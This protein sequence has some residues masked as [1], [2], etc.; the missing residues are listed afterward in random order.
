MDTGFDPV[1]MFVGLLALVVTFREARRSNRHLFR[2]VEC[3][4]S[5]CDSIAENSRMP[6]EKLSVTLKNIG[7]PSTNTRL[8]LA[9][10]TNTHF[11]TLRLEMQRID[12][13]GRP[14][15]SGEF[16][17]GSFATFVLKSY[18]HK[19]QMVLKCLAS[20]RKP[21]R[22]N[23]ARLIVE[24]D[25]FEIAVIKIGGLRDWLT[26]LW[27]D[28]AFRVNRYSWRTIY[29][30]GI[31]MLDCPNPLPTFVSVERQLQCYVDWINGSH[32]KSGSRTA[33]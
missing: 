29:L 28:V 10:R 22:L 6:F 4:A 3:T 7:L 26:G 31:K 14:A 11:G 2:V 30:D 12:Q 20:L 16:Q 23:K 9:V 19:D 1:A 27:N 32:A 21:V 18:Q 24:Q 15:N 17:K 8:V 25:G 5:V 13:M 33:A